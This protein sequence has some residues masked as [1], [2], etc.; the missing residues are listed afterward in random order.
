MD[1][2]GRPG[3]AAAGGT[4]KADSVYSRNKISQNQDNHHN[5]QATSWTITHRVGSLDGRLALGRVIEVEGDSHGGVRVLVFLGNRHDLDRWIPLWTHACLWIHVLNVSN[6]PLSNQGSASWHAAIKIRGLGIPLSFD[7]YFIVLQKPK[8]QA[9][10]HHHRTDPVTS[11]TYLDLRV[12]CIHQPEYVCCVSECK[13]G[14][15]WGARDATNFEKKKMQQEFDVLS[16][17]FT[18]VSVS[19]KAPNSEQTIAPAFTDGVCTVV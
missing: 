10:T 8:I 1:Y 11:R 17:F 16:F 13:K 14:A 2:S 7:K 18:P 15:A 9:K 4:R 3:K 6:P 12:L 19:L 5:L